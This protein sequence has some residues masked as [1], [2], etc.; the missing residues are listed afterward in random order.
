[1]HR[2]FLESYRVGDDFEP[3]YL[4]KMEYLHRTEQMFLDLNCQHL[5]DHPGSLSLYRQLVQYPH[6]IIP[7]M[8]H[9]VNELYS[10]F[11]RL[12]VLLD[13]FITIY[14]HAVIMENKSGLEVSKCG[15]TTWHRCHEC[16]SWT[17]FKSKV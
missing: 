2:Q 7:I 14:E 3:F 9:V 11:V 13:P 12:M 17:H 1:M 10:R 5:Q 4:R 6:D 8:D 15:P 16:E